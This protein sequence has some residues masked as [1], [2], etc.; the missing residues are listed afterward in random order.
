MKIWLVNLRVID[1]LTIGPFSGVVGVRM[2][3][4][5]NEWSVKKWGYKI[6]EHVKYEH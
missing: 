1:D 6:I 3:E 5:R 2:H 4:V